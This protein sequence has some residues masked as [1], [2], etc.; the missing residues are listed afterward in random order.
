MSDVDA[1]RVYA[2]DAPHLTRTIRG[3]LNKARVEAILALLDAQD[4]PDFRHK[5]GLI[6][7]IDTALMLCAELESEREKH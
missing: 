1:F 5:R 7:G 6:D 2:A 4:W 3:K